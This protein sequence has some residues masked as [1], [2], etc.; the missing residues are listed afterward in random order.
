MKRSGIEL[1]VLGSRLRDLRKT[2]CL[3]RAGLEQRHGISADSIKAWESGQV[4][5]ETKSL[6][7]YLKVFEQYHVEISLDTLLQITES[8][9][10][11]LTQPNLVKFSGNDFIKTAALSN[12]NSNKEIELIYN[13][14]IQEMDN[15]LEG[16][17]TPLRAFID[18]MP[19]EI[20]LKDD[21]NYVLLA[22]NKGA[23][24]MGGEPSDFI[25]KNCYDLLPTM[26]KKCHE[27]DMKAITTNAGL[28]NIIDPYEMPN[29]GNQL[30][31]VNKIPI[32]YPERNKKMIFVFFSPVVDRLP[33]SKDGFTQISM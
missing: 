17:D 21:N 29:G 30:I 28:T 9:P 5:I 32:H 13:L 22:N 18:N 31:C 8:N 25:N 14:L 12:N 6:R 33:V 19:L 24:I 1:S 3:S 2:I 27:D 16:K 15:V 10:N 4:E 20:F 11:D 7:N 26:S 23:R